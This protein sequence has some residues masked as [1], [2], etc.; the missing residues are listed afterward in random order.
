MSTCMPAGRKVGLAP[1]QSSA[2]LAEDAGSKSVKPRELFGHARAD[3]PAVTF[4]KGCW[5]M[6]GR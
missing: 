3:Q 1:V 4:S 5:S 2:Y 6:R